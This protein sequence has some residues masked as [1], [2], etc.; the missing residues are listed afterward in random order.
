MAVKIWIWLLSLFVVA[1]PAFAQVQAESFR[2]WLDNF[3]VEA[4]A[5]GVSPATLR[6]VLP[7]LEPDETVIE[8]DRKQPESRISFS[9]Y[10][11]NVM[12][13]S[14]IE[15]ARRVKDDYAQALR[16]I[17]AQTGVPPGVVVAL[18]GMES[19]FGANMG[20]YRVL[21][22]LA[23]L[24]FEGRRSAFFRK[25]F[26]EALKILDEEGAEAEALQGSWAGAMGQCQFM[27][28]TFRRFAV[29]YDGDGRRDIWT[30]DYDALASIAHYIRAEGWKAAE[31]WGIEVKL[32]QAIP[33][34]QTGLDV[35]HD[36]AVWNKKGVRTMAGK[37]L[38]DNGLSGS[39]VLP[40]GPGGRAF[41]VYDN[42]RALMRWNRSTYFAAS[43]GLLS[44]Q[45]DG[46]L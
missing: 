42:F 37:P 23:T 39:L 13:P 3:A 29:D 46:D 19:S 20:D 43:V 18:W 11:H 12:P 8:L 26:I 35:R 6:R 22:S 34:A 32:T 33:Q 28:S 10:L 44:D 16:G 9:A 14:R 38:K 45:I 41:L 7:T 30:N 4:E 27:P 31:P 36:A 15:K 40:D 17:A 21:D 2:A 25:E 24:A 1:S 5:Q